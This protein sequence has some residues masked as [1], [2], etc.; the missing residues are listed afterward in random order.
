MANVA[1]W[2]GIAGYLCFLGG[3]A[4]GLEKRVAQLELLGD[5]DD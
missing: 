5:R 3:K 2:L 4:S 1:V